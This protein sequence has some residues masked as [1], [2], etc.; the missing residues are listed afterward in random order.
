MPVHR[1]PE[2]LDGERVD[3]IVATLG[4]TSRSVARS[5]V[6]AGAVSSGETPLV[7]RDR[8]PAGAEVRFEPPDEV[9]LLRPLEVAFDVLYEDPHLVVVDKPA[10]LVTH[11]GSASQIV[12]LAAGLLHRYPGIEGVGDPGRWG[13]VH[14][15]DRDTSGLLVVA[16]TRPAHEGL[17]AAMR[18]RDV[19]RDYLA[20]VDGLFDAPRGTVDAPISADPA[21]PTRKIVSALGRPARTHYRRI[22]D[23]PGP[24]VSL[25][26]VE[27][28][29]GRTHQ[30]RVHLASIDHPVI[31]DRWYGRPARVDSP[32]VFLHAA[33][34]AFTH[35]VTGDHVEVRSVLPDDLS[36]VL[37][38]LPDPS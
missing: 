8:L 22:D 5:L 38:G 33:R 20:L 24:G 16:L 30:I 17:S 23:W 27:L 15:L 6:D 12:T 4:E 7:A 36:T 31:G 2:E 11:P 19:H 29:T 3:K 18:G 32:R 34:L 37:A 14:R 9:E 13:I 25:L 28:E 21:R 26:E 35:P 10:G 1:V